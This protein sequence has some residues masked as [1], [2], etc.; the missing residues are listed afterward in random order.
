MFQPLPFRRSKYITK[1]GEII[2]IMYS[3][4]CILKNTILMRNYEKFPEVT[5]C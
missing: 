4:N 3:N 5:L 1:L 2:E